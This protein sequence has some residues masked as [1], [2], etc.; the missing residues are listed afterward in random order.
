MWWRGWSGGMSTAVGGRGGVDGGDEGGCGGLVDFW[1]GDTAA[2]GQ[3]P[4]SGGDAEWGGGEGKDERLGY[5]NREE[6]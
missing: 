1:W 4:A 6:P 5:K 3:N 2:G